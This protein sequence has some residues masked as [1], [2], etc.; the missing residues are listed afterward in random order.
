MQLCL[1]LCVLDT[2]DPI[3]Q[4]S[5]WKQIYLYN[6]LFDGDCIFQYILQGSSPRLSVSF[7][8]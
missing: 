1:S 5:R 7:L 4:N 8:L 3:L 2:R 6:R